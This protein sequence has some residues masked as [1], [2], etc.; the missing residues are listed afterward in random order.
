MSRYSQ[1]YIC[2]E[3]RSSLN[4]YHRV[5]Y[6]LTNLLSI[7]QKQHST[8]LCYSEYFTSLTQYL[9]ITVSP[10]T[11]TRFILITSTGVTTTHTSPS[12]YVT[13]P[14][15]A[16]TI[17][18]TIKDILKNSDDENAKKKKNPKKPF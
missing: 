14:D 7:N 9:F 17:F 4:H 11:N 5:F 12:P 15:F 3:T 10:Y 2:K 6:S 1:S 18:N 8:R 13:Q 16:I